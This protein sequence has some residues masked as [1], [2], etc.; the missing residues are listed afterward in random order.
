[1][2]QETVFP[3]FD[4]EEAVEAL[5]YLKYLKNEIANDEIFKETE[6]VAAEA[7]FSGN[8]L[9]IRFWDMGY[10]NPLFYQTSSPGSKKGINT[11]TSVVSGINLA[12]NR[13]INEENVKAAYEVIKYLTSEEIQREII[14]KKYNLYTAITKLY[15]DE[16]ICSILSCPLVKK[17]R[18]VPRIL[19]IDDTEEKNN[20]RSQFLNE[21]LFG[22]KRVEEILEKIIGEKKFY[23]YS[24]KNPTGL[25]MFIV[26]L[27]LIGIIVTIFL[28]FN[29]KKYD[30]H[31][32]FFSKDMY[33]MY[34]VGIIITIGSEFFKFG[35]LSSFKCQMGYSIF[36]VGLTISYIPILY[37][38]LITIPDVG[39]SLKF[40]W[41]K[42]KIKFIIIGVL[43]EIAIN[44]LFIAAPFTVNDDKSHK[45]Y[46][47][48]TMKSTFAI[49]NYVILFMIRIYMLKD[50]VKTKK[51]KEISTIVT[52]TKSN[53]STD[54]G[55]V[56]NLSYTD[57]KSTIIEKIINYHYTQYSIANEKGLTY[58]IKNTDTNYEKND[59]NINYSFAYK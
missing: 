3:G 44:L 47:R 21:F 12:I 49:S 5:K 46:N 17:A 30:K 22:N 2:Q 1:K 9:F 8:G 43:I 34:C 19:E 31:Y 42:N 23:D 56:S 39:N 53:I 58:Y 4:S 14:V 35:N 10:P 33:W 24:I 27:A 45:N 15:D 36:F 13:F 37:K 18:T 57:S 26:L 59:S 29:Q 48:C 54:I 40:Y 55:D 50:S 51:Q 7:L 38:L 28:I 6:G 52:T 41:Q 11:N 25:I 20:Q 32:R 16:E